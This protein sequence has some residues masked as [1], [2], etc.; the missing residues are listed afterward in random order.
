MKMSNILAKCE[1]RIIIRQ[2]LLSIL[3]IVTGRGHRQ[4]CCESVLLL[5][6]ESNLQHSEKTV[7]SAVKNCLVAFVFFNVFHADNRTKFFKL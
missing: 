7:R 3:D 6:D 2:Y 4:C 5:A 1:V